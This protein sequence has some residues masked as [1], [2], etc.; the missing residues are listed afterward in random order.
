M[1]LNNKQIKDTP[2]LYGGAIFASIEDGKKDVKKNAAPGEINPQGGAAMASVQ[3]AIT[4]PSDVFSDTKLQLLRLCQM[5][6][7]EV[8]MDIVLCPS[9][10]VMRKKQ[11]TEL[12]LFYNELATKTYFTKPQI[13]EGL[14]RKYD[15]IEMSTDAS[16][17]FTRGMVSDVVSFRKGQM[18]PKMKEVLAL[19]RGKNLYSDRQLISA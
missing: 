14:G 2:G 15:V 9:C 1:K 17:I 18:F 7:T 3:G 6:K 11:S 16:D 8:E 12:K 10:A 13:E 19:S 4:A 5:C